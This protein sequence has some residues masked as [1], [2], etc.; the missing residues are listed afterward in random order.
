MAGMSNMFVFLT[1]KARISLEQINSAIATIE[2][3]NVPDGLA[4]ERNDFV[5]HLKKARKSVEDS[6]SIY[7]HTIFVAQATLYLTP[8]KQG[9]RGWL[10]EMAAPTAAQAAGAISGRGDTGGT[11]YENLSGPPIWPPPP[12]T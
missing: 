6:P 9:L 8:E 4:A 12:Y 3:S 7:R 5:H 2:S 10:E 11:P 1:T